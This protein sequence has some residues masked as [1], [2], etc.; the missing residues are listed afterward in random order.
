MPAEHLQQL[1]AA[2]AR[3]VDDR[4]NIVEALT[5]PY[6]RGRTEEMRKAFVKVQ[7]TVEAIER[8]I[9]HEKEIEE[10]GPITI[11]GIRIVVG[12]E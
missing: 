2:R 3:L 4:R 10:G 1:R 8:A 12:K 9:L 6:E 7:V 5:K 11:P